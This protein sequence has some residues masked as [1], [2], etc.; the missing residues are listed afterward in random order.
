[1]WTRARV[2]RC[3]CYIC[4]SAPVLSSVA[5]SIWSSIANSSSGY[6]ICSAMHYRVQSL[7]GARTLLRQALEREIRDFDKDRGA[8]IKAAQDKLKKA[9]AAAEAGRK[10]LRAAESA[11]ATAE[12]ERDAAGGEN[13]ALVKQIEAV[14]QA[15]AGAWMWN[16]ASAGRWCHGRKGFGTEPCP[17]WPPA[18]VSS[19]PPRAWPC[20][21]KDGG[22]K[23]AGLCL[24]LC[25]MLHCSRGGGGLQAVW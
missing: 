9:K 24:T 25:V 16:V 3:S 20:L 12:A 14:Q 19:C 6:I 11:L 7:L 18:C 5:S 23:R 1:M 8:R 17:V 21:R 4:G 15:V 13:E 22:R 2:L 10:A